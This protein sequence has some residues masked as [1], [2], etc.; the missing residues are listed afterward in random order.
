MAPERI[1]VVGAGIAGLHC[2]IELLKRG[3]TVNLYE[4]YDYVGGRMYTFHKKI[5]GGQ[6]QWE[7][8]AGRISEKHRL[9][10]GLFKQYNLHTIPIGSKELYKQDYTSSLEPNLFEPSLPVFFGPLHNLSAETLATRTIRQLCQEIYG[11]AKTEA[12]LNRFPYRAEVDIMR[13][14]MALSLFDVEMKSHDG[15]FVCKEGLSELAKRMRGDFVRRGG[16]IHLGHE[17]LDVDG[18]TAIFKGGLRPTADRII[19][20]MHVNAL[21]HI[22]RFKGWGVM[23]H[24]RM[25]PL[26]RVYA[27]YPAPGGRP[28]FA[29][30]PTVVTD[31]PVRYFI[32]TNE[33]AGEAMISYTDARDAEPLMA[34]SEGALGRYLQKE[35]RRLFPEKHIPAPIFLKTHPWKSGV[36]YWLPGRYDPATESKKALRFSERIHVCGESFSLRQGWMEGALEHAEMLL[37]SL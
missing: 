16:R 18:T 6:V 22:P 13:A 36:T 9:V 31:T 37:S 10:L 23:K 15:Y 27:K 28:W 12:L 25:T 3:H 1:T 32:P 29:G 8:G 7:A 11:P 35:L 30:L 19:L 14:D 5:P 33:A 26:L 4:K 34:M 2:A 20:A 21:H 17:L 24:L